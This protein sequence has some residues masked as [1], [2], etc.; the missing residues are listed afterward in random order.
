MS[1]P[2]L[3][4]IRV[5]AFGFAPK[6]WAACNGQVLSI[7]QNTAL[8]SLLGT[9]YGGNG[10]STF[11]LPNFQGNMPMHVGNSFDLGETGGEQVHFLTLQEYAH[12]HP[13]NGQAGP[14]VG[15]SPAGAV[16]AS[17]DIYGLGP[18]N[19]QLAASAVQPSG[20]N[21][22]HNNMQPY[23]TLNFCIALQGIYPSRS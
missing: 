7:Q 2:Y 10:T 14:R 6:G 4:E 22:G 23:L 13:V 12:D 19:G 8:F 21:Q 17:G 3:G 15:T 20:S 5:F 18:T 16:L 9:T 1:N 11:A